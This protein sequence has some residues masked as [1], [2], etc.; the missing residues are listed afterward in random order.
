MNETDALK[1]ENA[2]LKKD[3]V[4]AAKPRVKIT[5]ASIALNNENVNKLADGLKGYFHFKAVRKKY[6]TVACQLITMHNQGVA[7][8]LELRKASGLSLQGFSQQ[9]LDVRKAG[10]MIHPAQ[11]KYL[12]GDK[13]KDLLNKIFGE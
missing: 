8:S 1:A 12:L 7:T 6:V 4:E 10:L 9:S 11:G 2:Q 3:V 13:A 5:P